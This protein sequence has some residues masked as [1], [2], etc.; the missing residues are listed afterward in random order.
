MSQ[1][2]EMIYEAMFKRMEDLANGVAISRKVEA[3]LFCQRVRN[4]KALKL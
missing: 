4:V 3:P 2:G 1:E